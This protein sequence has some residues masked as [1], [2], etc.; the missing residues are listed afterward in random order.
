MALLHGRMM[1]Y[2]IS[3][4]DYIVPNGLG[5]SRNHPFSGNL[6]EKIFLALRQM[7]PKTIKKPTS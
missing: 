4:E 3:E 7:L 5:T 2:Q 1:A 6:C